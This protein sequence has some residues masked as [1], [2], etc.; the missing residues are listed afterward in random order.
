MV[1]AERWQRIKDLFNST[2]ARPAT[3]RARFLLKACGTDE[4]LRKEVESL[5]SAH[6]EDESFLNVPAYELAA[7]M[8]E[9]GKS[10]PAVGDRIGPYTILSSLGAG[11]M[12]E[13][14]LA[15]DSRLGRKIAL[16]LLA[17]EFAMDERRVRRF[18][19]EARAASALNH[20]NVCVI[21]EVGK[22]E[23]GRHFMAME[24]V[25]GVTLRRRMTRN[26]LTLP[27]ALDVAAQVAWALEAAHAAGIVHRDIKPENIMLRRDGYVKVLDFGIA[28]LNA[29]PPRIRDLHEAST[30]RPLHTAP[31]SL[32]GTVK[33]MSPE[34]LRELPID[35]RTDIWSLGVVL[36]EMV[37]GFTPFEAHTTNDTIAIILEKQPTR[38]D[39]YSNEV[40]EE[41]RQ[42][43]RKALSKKRGER[44]QL[45][46]EFASELRKLR[47]QLFSE[48]ASD[49]VAQPTLS[50][51]TTVRSE[52]PDAGFFSRPTIFS[53]IRSQAASTADY[54]LS[55]IKEHKRAM[56]F[57]GVTA[58]FAL[59]FIGFYS[60]TLF[61]RSQP[62]VILPTIKMTP[63][64][65]AGK[66]VCAAISPDG[67]DVAHAEEKDGMQELLVTRIAN[68]ATSI[69]V[70]RSDVSY[71]G[72]TFSPDGNYLYFTR[73]EKSATGTLYQL[74]LPGSALR[75]MKS[76]VDSPISFSP[77]GDRFAFVRI[78][79]INHEYSLI[80]DE[81]NGT[82]ERTIATRRDGNRF[83]V[84]GPAWSPDA[85]TIACAAGWWNN[86]YQMNLVEVDVESG[87]ERPIS[88][89]RWFS[90]QQVAW[91]QDKS[92]LILGAREQP[93]SPY[94]LWRISY[95]KG[96][97]AR[98]TTDTTEYKSLSLS[99]DGNTLVAVQSN[100]NARI[101]VSPERDELRARPIASTVGLAYGLNWTTNGKIVFSSMAGNNL[102]IWRIDTDGSNQT[103]LT[104]NA[105]DNY[106]PT[107]TAD[108]RFIVFASNRNGSFNIWRMVAED[109]SDPRQLTFGDGNFYPSV[110]ADNQ[111]LSYDN[112]SGAPRTVWKMP[113]D[114][115]IP[116]QLSDQYARMPVFSPDNQFIA[117][118][119]YV[120]PGVLG[121]AILPF[122]GGAP[123]KL[124]P[125]AIMDWQ[126]VQWIANG[127]ALSYI[128][129]VNGVSNIWS[130]ELDTGVTKQLTD[131]KADQIFSYGWSPDYKQLALQRGATVSDVTIISY[132]R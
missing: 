61:K 24:Y 113:I 121:I 15:K 9:K 104:V 111:W 78:N 18:E 125:I 131:F 16:K 1:T 36:H 32:M 48:P 79:R 88:D 91:F 107:T 56:V 69:V 52:Q 92:G 14:Y 44:Y 22:T 54:V 35:A 53:K 6:E 95:P 93:M 126:Q 65:N 46:S 112:Q 10:Q 13:V 3:E 45:M 21:H 11:G 106:T 110:S 39:Y 68:A 71:Q 28:K 40:P 23:D 116:V 30:A 57:T 127:G 90:I 94:Q 128:K 51:E 123:V 19:Q 43:I 87:Q 89:R 67:R 103:Q 29:P 81:I 101:W 20:P 60:P 50:F 99:R 132:V 7:E 47:R 98:L 33:Y 42:V 49:P 2:L 62:S 117:C 27:Q 63:L 74:A 17:S 96:E 115:G 5:L 66:S 4:S 55:E 70:P 82:A 109:G 80:V 114:G 84:E 120:E 34:Q 102:N 12:G 83:A 108:G 8:L 73:K 72:L 86:G 129:S 100:Q 97:P 105:G 37:T 76:G 58:V 118:R 25:E 59:L 64:T 26:R 77:N 119:Y 122:H 31:G 75:K 130:Y 85:K 41:F 38:L 124:L